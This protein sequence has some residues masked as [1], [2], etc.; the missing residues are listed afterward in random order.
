MSL[1]LGEDLQHQYF[2]TELPC[3]DLLDNLQPDLGRHVAIAAD[4][5][6]FSGPH[7]VAMAAD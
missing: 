2:T 3:L 1:P 4:S 6:R 7:H 5:R